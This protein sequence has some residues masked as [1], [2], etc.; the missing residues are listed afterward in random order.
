MLEK[1]GAGHHL[2]TMSGHY[3]KHADFRTRILEMGV[4]SFTLMVSTIPVD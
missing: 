3:L 4:S 2:V 1:G